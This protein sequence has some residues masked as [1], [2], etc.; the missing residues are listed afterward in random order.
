MISL[1]SALQCIGV[2]RADVSVLR[3]LLGFAR[4]VLPTDPEP[5]TRASVSLKQVIEGVQGRHVHLNVIRVGWDLIPEANLDAARDR[6]D[7]SVYRARNILRQ[8][9][10]GVGRVQHWVISS[11]DAD[12]LDDIASRGETSDLWNGWYVD[13]D[14]VDVFVVRTISASGFI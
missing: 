6:L 13:N 10:L 11:G 12:G 8:R 3:H 7:Y 9:S 1:R 14:G 5:D 2:S 4:G